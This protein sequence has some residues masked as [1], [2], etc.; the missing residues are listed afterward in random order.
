MSNRFRLLIFNRT[1]VPNCISLPNINSYNN[2]ER[3]SGLNIFFIN[4]WKIEYNSLPL[5]RLFYHSGERLMPFTL[6]YVCEALP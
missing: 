3:K 4:F 6:V 2:N 5:Q 1:L